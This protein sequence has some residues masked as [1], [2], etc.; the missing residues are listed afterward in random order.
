MTHTSVAAPNPAIVP[1][2]QMKASTEQGC[3]VARPKLSLKVAENDVVAALAVGT[4]QAPST[5]RGARAAA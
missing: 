5:G 2:P 4:V 1:E 3:A